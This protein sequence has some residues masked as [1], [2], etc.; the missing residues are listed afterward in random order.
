MYFVKTGGQYKG[1]S[2]GVTSLFV[3]TKGKIYGIAKL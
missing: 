2:C 1:D 3:V